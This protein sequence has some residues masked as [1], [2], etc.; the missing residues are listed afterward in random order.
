MKR[1]HSGAAVGARPPMGPKPRC[2]VAEERGTG[3]AGQLI[4]EELEKFDQ[5][6]FSPKKE[7]KIWGIHETDTDSRKQTY[8]GV[9]NE[10]SNL[11][12]VMVLLK[13]SP[14]LELFD[15]SWS[16]PWN[17]EWRLAKRVVLPKI[18]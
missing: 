16:N 12:V 10:E 8:H 9:E 5:G 1:K 13:S 17:L 14:K 7:K 18:G 6:G 2:T 11:L 4:G 3:L 15:T